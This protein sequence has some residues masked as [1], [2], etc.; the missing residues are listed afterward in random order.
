VIP[1]PLRRD[2]RHGPLPP[3]LLALTLVTGLVDAVSIL[4]L[5]RVFVANMTGNVVFTGFALAGAPGFSLTAS[6]SAMAGFLVA[7]ALYGIF[8]RR[9]ADDR[10]LLLLAAAVS[11]L[12]L[13]T[14]ALAVTALGP[15]NGVDRYVVA[16][17]LAL[18][19]GSQNA[20]AR[21]L[22]VPDM[23][24]TVLTTTLAGLA[25]EL[26]AGNRGSALTRRLLVVATMLAGALL[27]AW[28]VLSVSPAA[29]LAVAVALL[30][31]VTIAAA[32]LTRHPAT[33]PPG[34]G[35]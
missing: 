10:A 23:T 21:R 12:A 14:A 34:V 15:L 33:P 27:G 13:V 9:I 17:L 25:S 5:G 16:G 2:P 22:A 24:T 30:V 8:T 19:M 29:A 7:A 35:P 32:T 3:L 4:K 26:P 6:L 18:A 20:A 11:E 1:R 28:L 31:T